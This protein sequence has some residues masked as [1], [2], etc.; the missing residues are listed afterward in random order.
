MADHSDELYWRRQAI[1]MRLKGQLPCEI[2]THIPRKRGWLRKWWQRFTSL[3]WIV[4][5]A[6]SGRPVH[7]PQAYNPHAH[8][9]VLTVRRALEQRQV[10]LVG[11]RAIQ[12]EILDH[13]LLPEVPS[14]ATIK[15]WLHTAGIAQPVGEERPDRYYPQPA[16][17]AQAVW[18]ACDWIARYLEGGA[19]VFVFH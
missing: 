15:R 1:R 4:L 16:R 7:A 17:P 19:K 18:H 13:R 3:G 12:Q 6:R 8:T 9:V 11:A 14:L 5:H 2:L 10:G